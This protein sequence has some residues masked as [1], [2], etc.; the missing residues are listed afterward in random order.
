MLIAIQDYRESINYVDKFVF[1]LNIYKGYHLLFILGPSPPQ[2]EVVVTGSLLHASI[3]SN[4]LYIKK[5][6]Q[7]IY[8]TRWTGH[9]ASPIFCSTTNQRDPCFTALLHGILPDPALTSTYSIRLRLCHWHLRR[10]HYHRKRCCRLTTL[11][12]DA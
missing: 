2:Q 10:D 9:P 1:T 11:S 12:I 4:S 5:I 8:D 7:R 3:P 6:V